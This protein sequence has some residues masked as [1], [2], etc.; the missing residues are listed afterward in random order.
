MCSL[1]TS[2]EINRRLEARRR[3]VKYQEPMRR[4]RTDTPADSKECPS[5]HTQNPSTAKF[6]V[7]CGEKLETPPEE[8]GFSPE[9]KG[10]GSE[11]EE[12]TTVEKP[13]KSTVTQ[14]PDDFGRGGTQ[15]IKDSIAPEP[16]DEKLEP[17]VPESTEPGKPEPPKPPLVK[18]PESIP[19][20]EV[21]KA[22]PTPETQLKEPEPSAQEEKLKSDVDPV[23]RIKKTKELLDIGAITQ[24]EFDIIKKKYLDEI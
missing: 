12:S 5:C 1:V 20:P 2:D 3:G 24:E 18:R 16:A 22:T 19:T 17:I 7:G 4:T 13:I 14:R 9:I 15:K 10:S 6:C 23:E 11:A 8:E 21:K